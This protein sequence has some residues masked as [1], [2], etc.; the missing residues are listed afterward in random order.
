LVILNWK[1]QISNTFLN[2]NYIPNLKITNEKSLNTLSVAFESQAILGAIT[3]P[4]NHIAVIGMGYVG[5]PAAALFADVDRITVTGIQRRSTRSGWKIDYLNQGK[6]PIGGDEPGLAELLE[7]V[8]KNNKFRVVDDYSACQDADAILIDVQTP[9][10]RDH[11]PRYESLKSVC[12]EIG[13]YLKPGVLVVI[14]STV[15]PG[16]TEFVAKP[17]LEESSGKKAGADFYLA[18]SYERVMVGRL[19]HNLTYY[20]RIIGGI[21]EKSTE[22]ALE[23]YKFIV[24][25]DLLPTTALTAEVAKVVENTYRDVNIAFA[26]EVALICESLGIDAYKVRKLVNSLPNDPSNPAAN[27]YRNMH[28]PGGGVG[29]HCLPKDPWLLKYGLDHYGKIKFSP[30]IIIRCRELNDSMPNHMVE[31]LIRGLNDAGLGIDGAKICVLGL[32]FLEN[33]DDTRNTPTIPLFQT[34]IEKKA[35]V[36]IHDPFIKRFDEEDINLTDN[37]SSALQDA[38]AIIIMTGHRQYFEIDLGEL[39]SAMKHP[40]IIDGRNL[41]KTEECKKHGFIYYAVGKG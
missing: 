27:P 35:T 5:I 32:A 8:V 13:P 2:S 15:A 39:K 10:E 21:D 25:A 23:L 37:L 19:L 7:K 40:V 20:S 38:D 26:N 18:F 17:I 36:I 30:E 12:K 1:F 9:V 41:F 4:F 11:E 34:L 28:F 6:C 33:S 14:E 22:L 29:G 16:T 31:L 24:K 3:M